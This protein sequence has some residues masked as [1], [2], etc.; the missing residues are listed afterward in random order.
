MGP[1]TEWRVLAGKTEDDIAPDVTQLLRKTPLGNSESQGSDNSSVLFVRFFGFAG[2][3]W[4]LSH[5]W[6]GN[7]NWA[8]SDVLTAE[9]LPEADD[10]R[11]A[12]DPQGL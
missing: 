12:Q 1:S 9:Q 10:I 4:S 2:P 3:F 7:G 5:S 8:D 11:V 6:H